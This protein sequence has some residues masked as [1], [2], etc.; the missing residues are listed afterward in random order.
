MCLRI[1]MKGKTYSN[2]RF[3]Y[4]FYMNLHKLCN[5]GRFSERLNCTMMFKYKYCLNLKKNV[6]GAWASLVAQW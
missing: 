4:E 6:Q 2:L 5:P 3:S 1:R